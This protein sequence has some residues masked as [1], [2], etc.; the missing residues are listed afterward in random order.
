MLDSSLVWLPAVVVVPPTR[1]LVVGV[2]SLT[3]LDR[4]M[5]TV[6]FVSPMEEVFE[7]R[8]VMGI[9]RKKSSPMA[10]LAIPHA[11]TAYRLTVHSE[12]S[13]CVGAVDEPTDCVGAVDGPT[14]SSL[15][16]G[17]KGPRRS[18]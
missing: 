11:T 17:F 14:S 2:E 4:I 13:D 1:Y 10:P 8:K 12:P 3:H 5:T 18:L 6:V 15:L 9:G 7:P 16:L